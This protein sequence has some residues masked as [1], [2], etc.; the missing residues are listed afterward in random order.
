MQYIEFFKILEEK[1]TLTLL[2]MLVSVQVN[3]SNEIK[4]SIQ[5]MR[6]IE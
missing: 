1:K 6:N 2:S 3:K 4:Y 5:I